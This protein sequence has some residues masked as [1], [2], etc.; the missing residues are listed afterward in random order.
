MNWLV[1]LVE[2]VACAAMLF[3]AHGLAINVKFLEPRMAKGDRAIFVVAL[4]YYALFLM[5]P[6]ALSHRFLS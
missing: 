3:I 2:A 1:I 6:I 5:I 4:L